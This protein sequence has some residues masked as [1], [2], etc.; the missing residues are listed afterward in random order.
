MTEPHAC[1]DPVRGELVG[2]GEEMSRLTAVLEEARSGRGAAV[3][4]SGE[5]GV[6]KTRFAAEVIAG[7]RAAGMLAVRGCPGTV[8]GAVPYRPLVEALLA[9]ARTGRLPAPGEPGGHGRV[10]ARLL[11]GNG[12]IGGGGGTGAVRTRSSVVPPLTAAEAILRTIAGAG[13]RRGFLL[14][15]D[16]LHEADPGTLAVVDYLVDQLAAVPVVLLAT[17][18][19]VRG[20][21]HGA[22][23]ALAAR[24]HR[25]L[26]LAPL[27]PADVRRMASDELRAGRGEPA[28][29]LV[30]RVTGR[31]V[32]E[33]GG[34]PFAVRELARE[35]ATCGAPAATGA[36]PTV[37]AN[38]LRRTE[39]LGPDATRLL[40]VAAL[41]GDAF[42]VPALACATGRTEEELAPLLRAAAHA[43]LLVPDPADPEL[44]AFRHA[45]A[46]RA[47][48][49]GLAPEE[50]TRA[51]RRAVR[52][53][54]EGHPGLPGPWCARAAAL[55]AAAGDT[56]AA[57]RH[58]AEAAR[59]ATAEGAPDRALAL[60][61]TAHG[62]LSPAVPSEARA[63]VRER[64]LDAAVLTGH[65]AALPA[66]ALDLPRDGHGLPAPRRA[67]LHARLARVHALAGRP[68]EALRHLDLARWLLGGPGGPGD[69]GGPSGLR[70]SRDDA[71]AVA[72]VELAAAHVEPSRLAPER[73]RTAATAARRALATALAAELPESAGRALLA[74]GHLTRNTDADT[75]A[76]HFTR[77]RTLVPGPAGIPLRIAADGCLARLVLW[78]DGV[79][80]AVEEVRREALRA[81]LAPQ[82]HELGLALA[83]DRVRRGESAAARELIR[84]G[85]ADASHRGL[86]RAVALWRLA[87]AVRAAHRGRRDELREA[88]ERFDPVADAAPGLRAMEFGL[89]RGFCSLLEEDREAAEREFAQALACHAENPATGDFGRYGVALLCGVLAGR[90]GRRHHD[91]ATAASAAEARWNRPFAGLADAVLLG[92]EGRPDRATAAAGAALRAAAPYPLARHLGLRLV[93]RAAYEDGWGAPAEWAREA[94][95]YFH[96]AGLPAVAGACRA[97]LRSMGAP[98]RQRRSGTELVPPGLRRCGIT[99]REF[100]VARLL[101]ERFGNRDIAGRLHISPRTVEKHVASLLQKTGHPNRAAFASAARELVAGAAP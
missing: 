69:L 31:A 54:A 65:L 83:L 57:V 81:G 8:D 23:A 32:D 73:L 6:G 17:T 68:E 95:E 48:R 24:A 71:E 5:P 30:R 11:G 36:P 75:A 66:D 21:G 60:L 46:G 85:E 43:F 3:F 26:A 33:C 58:Y 56:E 22:V 82:A 41:F 40:G 16:D 4:V 91:R 14:V 101:A 63:A 51:A 53:M 64:L 97:L 35:L 19:P 86:G 96:G 72:V 37:A 9:L 25:T 50:R 80:A 34:L 28:P 94:E 29:E 44:F 76:Q 52:A 18:V 67:A 70:D 89:A 38:V 88:L 74:L 90:A 20:T 61:T 42:A 79:A 2:R 77:A 10:L 49:E 27:A 78:R 13:G 62:L 7:A 93:A 87:D 45:L 59:R 1:T 100:E 15:L 12:G 92:R 98:V 55:H 99:V 47:L 84:D 39:R